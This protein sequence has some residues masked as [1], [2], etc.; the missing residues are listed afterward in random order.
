MWKPFDPDVFNQLVRPSS[1]N[2]IA[3]PERRCAE[4]LGIVLGWIEVE[5]AEIGP[6]QPRR[7]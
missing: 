7:A 3:Q 2:E 6:V 5:D 1:D 4:D